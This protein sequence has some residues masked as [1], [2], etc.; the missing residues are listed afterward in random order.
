VNEYTVELA[1]VEHLPR[2]PAI[3]L[4]AA[5]LFPDHVLTPEIRAGVVPRQ[6]MEEAQEQD[7]LWV[8]LDSAKRPVGFAVA[9][10][11]GDAAF[12]LEIDVHPD[13]Q[14]RGLGRKLIQEVANWSK[15]QRFTSLSLTTFEHVPWNAPFYERLGF[16]RLKAGELS[17]NL[18]HRLEDERRQGLKERVAMQLTL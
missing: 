18:L 4:A 12:L 5:A 6:Q 1:R 7:R 11:A 3:E 8:A 17:D 9:V 14:R 2:L 15:E 13:H 10:P 16:R